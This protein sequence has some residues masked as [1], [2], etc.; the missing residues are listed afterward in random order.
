MMGRPSGA[1]VYDDIMGLVKNAPD[2]W[3]C[4]R[5]EMARHV[6]QSI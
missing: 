3:I 6:L 5:E 1:W 4:T 2:V